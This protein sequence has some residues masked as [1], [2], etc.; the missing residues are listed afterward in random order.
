M[1][2]RTVLKLPV[3]GPYR[4]DKRP[5]PFGPGKKWSVVMV[6]PE[7]P[8]VKDSR[9]L[10]ERGWVMKIIYQL[11]PITFSDLWEE[12]FRSPFNPIHTRTQ[13]RYI[14]RHCRKDLQIYLRL[15]PDDLQFYIYMYPQWARLTRHFIDEEKKIDQAEAA[16]MA[17]DPPPAY[18]AD[19][20]R[21]Y[22]QFL[23]NQQQYTQRR[24]EELSDTEEDK[25]ETTV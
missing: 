2:R 8:A 3:G 10:T 11:Q 5:R 16:R 14:M 9:C 18:P 4:L 6:Q 12:V 1:L 15:D 25:M 22:Y 7:G 20:L 19:P 23:D 24:I 13:L 17:S 21:Y